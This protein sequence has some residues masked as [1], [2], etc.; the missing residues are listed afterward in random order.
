MKSSRL[1]RILVHM[2]LATWVDLASDFRHF[3]RNKPRGGGR[4]SPR[5]LGD[6]SARHRRRT[7]RVERATEISRQSKIFA[8]GRSHREYDASPRITLLV[9]ERAGQLQDVKN[10]SPPNAQRPLGSLDH[11]VCGFRTCLGST[12]VGAEASRL[13]R[14]RSSQCSEIT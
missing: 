4:A 8:N 1:P 2:L 10:E 9:A 5:G 3:S 12:L 6:Y 7:Q 13:R 11:M 14:Q